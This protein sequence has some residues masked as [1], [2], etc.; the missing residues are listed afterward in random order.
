MG[1]D[2]KPIPTHCPRGPASSGHLPT[3][4]TTFLGSVSLQPVSPSR[5]VAR[6]VRSALNESWEAASGYEPLETFSQNSDF[7]PFSSHGT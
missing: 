1:L 3:Q 5:S 2:R 4:T 6:A 7:Q